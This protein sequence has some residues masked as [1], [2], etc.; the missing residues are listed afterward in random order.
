MV[1]ES[2][3]SFFNILRLFFMFTSP[4]VFLVGIFLLYDINTYMRIERFL[5]KSYG[6]SKTRKIWMKRLEKHR[7]SLQMFLITRR[8]FVGVIC[9]VNAISSFFITFFLLKR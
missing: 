6:V 3:L 8:S 7:E 2:I 1:D 4:I 5:A 9:L